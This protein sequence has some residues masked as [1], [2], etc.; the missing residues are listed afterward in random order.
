M[1]IPSSLE[2][3]VVAFL[4]LI[5]DNFFDGG[6]GSWAAGMAFGCDPP[7]PKN[8]RRSFDLTPFATFAE[9]AIEYCTTRGC[10]AV[11]VRVCVTLF[12]GWQ[13]A[14]NRLLISNSH[15]LSC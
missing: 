2:I 15:A 1:F 6:S 8:I 11:M 13:T 10:H 3:I 9:G 5:D 12:K 14:V 7:G 4:G